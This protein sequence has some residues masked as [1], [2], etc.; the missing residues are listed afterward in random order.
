MRALVDAERL[1]R[2]LNALGAEADGD[3]RVYLTGGATAVLMGWRDSTIDVD[4]KLVPELDSLFRA[5]PR[6]KE[7]LNLNVELASPGDFIPELPG[8][9]DR[10]PFICR[11]GRVSFHHYDLSAQALAKIERAH[12]QDAVDVREML[13]RGLIEP[14][15]TWELYLAIEPQLYRYPALDPVAFRAAAAAA[16]GRDTEP[17]A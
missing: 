17:P 1:R 14:A 13:A 3:A 4:L 15:R 9:Q 2:F 5:I 12:D 6:L 16:L 7:S 10:S 11:E 8:W